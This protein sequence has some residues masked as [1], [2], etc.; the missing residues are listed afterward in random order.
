MT[1]P[2]TT[3][4][5]LWINFPSQHSNFHHRRNAD[6]EPRKTAAPGIKATTMTGLWSEGV[7]GE[8]YKHLIRGRFG[9]N[10]TV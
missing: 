6:S 7:G 1:P 8:Y 9:P 10:M 3:A 4:M 2:N 5:F